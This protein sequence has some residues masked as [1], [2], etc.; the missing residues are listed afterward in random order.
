MEVSGARRPPPIAWAWLP[1]GQ[2]SEMSPALRHIPAGSRRA[3]SW[4]AHPF[5]SMSKSRAG[6]GQMRLGLAT[7]SDRTAHIHRPQLGRVRRI[8]TGGRRFCDWAAILQNRQGLGLGVA[9]CCAKT[10]HAGHG[11]GSGRGRCQRAPAAA[12]VSG[13][14]GGGDVEEG[15]AWP[16]VRAVAQPLAGDPAGCWSASP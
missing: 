2:R 5:C 3:G 12:M 15:A 13:L 16:T 6:R 7:G 1:F 9:A 11:C 10:S 4:P 8:R 14:T